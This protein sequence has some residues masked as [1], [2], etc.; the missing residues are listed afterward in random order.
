MQPARLPVETNPMEV[1][2]H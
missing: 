2:A 1:S